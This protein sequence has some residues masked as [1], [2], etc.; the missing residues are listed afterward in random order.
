MI[1]L[2]NFNHKKKT[3]IYFDLESARRAV[4]HCEDV[5]VLQFCHFFDESPESDFL[6]EASINFNERYASIFEESLLEQNSLVRRN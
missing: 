4:P 6:K 3:W 2:K 5:P 1:D